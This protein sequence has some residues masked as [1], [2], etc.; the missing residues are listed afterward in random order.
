M[1]EN[2]A[3]APM[4]GEDFPAIKVIWNPQTQSVGLEFPTTEFRTWE[5][6]KAVLGMA[7][8]KADD[9]QRARA[10]AQM[11]QAQVE[12]QRTQAL[13]QKILRG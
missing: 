13:H 7:L 12:Q 9:I 5:F 11:M 3:A 4:R 1:N 2:G 10:A 6:I 8:A